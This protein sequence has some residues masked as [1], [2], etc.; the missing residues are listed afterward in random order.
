[1]PD[2]YNATRLINLYDKNGDRMLNADECRGFPLTAELADLDVDK[3]KSV[4]AFELAKKLATDFQ[5]SGVEALDQWNAVQYIR[6]H[7]QNDDRQLD[8]T[9]TRDGNWSSE[10]AQ[11]DRNKDGRLTAMEIATGL[12]KQKQEG[13][14]ERSDQ[15]NAARFMSMYDRNGD[16]RLDEEEIKAGGWPKD[17]DAFDTNN[18]GVLTVLEL[19]TRF[20]HNRRERGVEQQDRVAAAKLIARYDKDR[21]GSIDLN[22]L[23]VE[24]EGVAIFDTELFVQFDSDDNERLSR[25][26]VATYLARLRKNKEKKPD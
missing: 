8:A 4:S 16:R 23:L 17:P 7:D 21:N 10:P 18:D 20:A 2:T 9:E 22:E 25:M 5:K 3:D 14:V 12:A 19:A 24:R 15:N 11:F 26:E 6:K 1:L 13:G